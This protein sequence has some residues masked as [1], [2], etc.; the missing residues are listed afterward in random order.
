M[1]ILGKSYLDLLFILLPGLFGLLVI[2]IFP[3]TNALPFGV[4]ILFFIVKSLIDSGHVYATL[5]RTLFSKEELLSSKRYLLTPVILTIVI[6]LWTILQ[7]PYFQFTLFLTVIWHNVRQY[8]G[9]QKWYQKI[10]QR[11]SRYPDLFFNLL[12]WIPIVLA[13]LNLSNYPDNKFPPTIFTVGIYLYGVV[14]ASWIFYEILLLQ[15]GINEINR[16]LAMAI[17]IFLI[18]LT[19]LDKFL[20]PIPFLLAHGV[21]YIAIMTLSM[22]KIRPTQ[23]NS[24]A[25]SLFLIL[26]VVIIFGTIHGQWY[27]IVDYSSLFSTDELTS[28]LKTFILRIPLIPLLCHYYWDG[29]IWTQKHR[30]AKLIYRIA[31]PRLG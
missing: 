11:K 30:E 18:A 16:V 10:N 12:V 20:N 14:V 1:W 26:I 21:P 22:K 9:I 4:A 2:K 17:P 23:F 13:P 27:K 19:C 25:K 8:Y 3:E 15:K 7:I 31:P 6:F 29:F 24:L 5:W 28:P